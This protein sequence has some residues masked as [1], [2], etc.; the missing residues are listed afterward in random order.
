VNA[1]A[2]FDPVLGLAAPEVGWVPTPSHV[3]RRAAILEVLRDVAPGRLL[4]VGCG[5]GALLRDFGA[6]GFRGMAVDDSE[7]AISLARVLNSD[8]R[9][10]FEV[11][12]HLP[13]TADYDCLFAFEVL[14]HVEDD[15][16]ALRQWLGH[17]QV[18]GTV[19]IS[20]PAHRSRWSRADEWAGHVRRYDREDLERLLS[21]AGCSVERIAC[22]GFP[23]LNLL[24]PLSDLSSRRKLRQKVRAQRPMDRSNAT[25]SSGTDRGF[26]RR[27][28]PAYSSGLARLAFRGAIALQRRYLSSERGTGYLAVAR[29]LWA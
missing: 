9:G 21:D 14:E 15:T 5:A 10:Q 11:S 7:A 28:Y 23:A 2:D 1:V 24:A 18:G 25:A 19:V 26:E 20:V 3:L 29:K 13:A 27:F 8:I 4:E 17:V 12:R 16:G 22:Y 6:M